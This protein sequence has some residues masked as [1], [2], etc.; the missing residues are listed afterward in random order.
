MARLLA[1]TSPGIGHLYP[2][3][4]ALL[5]LQRRGHHVALR[6]LASQVATM[7]GLGFDAEAIDPRIEALAHDDHAARTP[8]EALR[9]AT[10][11]FAQRGV[12]EVPDLRRSIDAV[13]PDAVLVDTNCWGANAQAQAWGGP[14]AAFQPFPLPVSVPG[15]PPF[16]P[17]F[18]PATGALGRLRDALLRPVLVGVLSRANLPPVNAIRRGLGLAPLADLEQLYGAAPVLLYFTA[19]PFEYARDPWPS[20]VVLTGPMA[21]DPPTE[22]PA[23]V[24]G[25]DRPIVLVTTSSE[26]LDDG[27]LVTTAFE[28]LRDEPVFV[29]ATLPAGDPGAFRVP[30]NARLERFLPHSAILPRAA[31]A[32]TH[33]GMGAT[34]KAL[35]HGVPVCAVPFARDQFEVARR[36]EVAG[37]G[38]RLPAKQLTPQALRTAVRT[39]MGCRAGAARVAEGYRRAGGAVTAADAIEARV[40]GR[41]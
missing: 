8:Q 38:A 33:G 37:A 7:R 15:I 19:E 24:A 35:A 34:Q 31:V 36:V 29:L 11:T 4:A 25:I 20:N 22:V 30:P 27:R 16:G 3:T 40:L 10:R 12:H 41:A 28:A 6:C 14:W 26:F 23:W 39:A 17:G 21:W 13:G 1:Y 9:R 32:I 5:E 18:A 2:L